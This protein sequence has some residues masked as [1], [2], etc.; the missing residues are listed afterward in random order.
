M[1]WLAGIALSFC[2]AVRAAEPAAAPRKPPSG[3]ETKPPAAERKPLDLRIGDVRKYM[4]PDEYRANLTGREEEKNTVVVEAR[5]PLLP[6]ES[7]K[8]VPPG[9]LGLWHAVKHPS[10]AWRLFV[11]DPRGPAIGP[12]E[13]K[14]PPPFSAGSSRPGS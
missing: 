10:Q 3:T 12:P 4:L 11:P 7:E 2:A 1:K 13:V 5:V 9:L 8:P 6:M 14:V